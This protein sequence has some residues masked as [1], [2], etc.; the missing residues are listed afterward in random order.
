[1]GKKPI[2]DIESYINKSADCKTTKEL[3]IFLDYLD[4][5]ALQ[6]SQK[7]SKLYIKLEGLQV[8]IDYLNF[9]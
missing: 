3:K 1:M 5:R 6:F 8:L 2:F 7:T 9:S 4:Y